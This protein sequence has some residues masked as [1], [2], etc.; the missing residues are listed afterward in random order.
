ME[1]SWEK[2]ENYQKNLRCI[3]EAAD[4]LLSHM[5]GHD[6]SFRQSITDDRGQFSQEKLRALVEELLSLWTEQVRAGTATDPS[7]GESVA[8]SYLRDRREL[9]GL[10]LYLVMRCT[11]EKG[12]FSDA[13]NGVEMNERTDFAFLLEQAR[14]LSQ[15]WCVMAAPDGTR[16]NELYWGFD[17]YFGFHLYYP[18][19]DPGVLS[20]D[21]CTGNDWSLT[22]DWRRAC[23]N[24]SQL[25]NEGHQKRLH[26]KHSG[27]RRKKAKLPEEE[28]ETE[29]PEEER[30][31]EPPEEETEDLTPLDEE[32]G[33]VEDGSWESE[34]EEDDWY[35]PFPDA[36]SYYE[37][38]E[39]D[40]DRRSDEFGRAWKL[41]TLA[42]NFQGAEEYCSAC[43]RFAELF[44]NAKPEVLRDFYMELEEIADLYLSQR[45]IAPLADTDKMLDVYSRVCNGPGRQAR[46][47]GRGIQWKDL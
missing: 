16:R 33:P 2:Y 6:W 8:D 38:Q 37:F 24:D 14:Q 5:K 26:L 44:Q 9:Y 13:R 30:E 28:R 32:N 22:P 46:R 34:L 4:E 31:A 3:Q 20:G 18:L 47:Y 23:D 27:F 45:E 40:W 42:M 7:T 12:A 1:L 25:T 29:L 39:A 35:S 41:T 36:Q 11:L 15:A 19:N 10:Y 17:A 43:R 21:V